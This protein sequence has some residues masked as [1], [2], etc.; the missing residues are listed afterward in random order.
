MKAFMDFE[1]C[2]FLIK[3]NAAPFQLNKRAITFS[4]CPTAGD[5]PF[6]LLT[7]H[8]GG[9]D[10]PEPGKPESFNV[11]GKM[12]KYNIKKNKSILVIGYGDLNGQLL[13]DAYIQTF[14][15]SISKGRQFTEL[16]SDVPTPPDLPSTYTL[17]VAIG[18]PVDDPDAPVDTYGCALA[19]VGGKSKNLIFIN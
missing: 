12:T 14:T 19:T 2:F 11:S 10:P 6:D 9:P 5:H 15:E 13:H 1:D 16:A 4:A 7:V 17:A 18:D 8:I 3:V